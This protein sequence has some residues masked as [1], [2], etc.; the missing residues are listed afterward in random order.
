MVKSQS[1]SEKTGLNQIMD[2]I[3]DGKNPQEIVKDWAADANH[4]VKKNPW[5][6]VAGALAI[7]YL[8]G[9]W[10]SGRRSSVESR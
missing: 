7:G 1:D 4:F 2:E 3:F 10:S 9:S 5:V 8:L 6:A